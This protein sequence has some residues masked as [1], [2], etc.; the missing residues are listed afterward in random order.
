MHA[1]Y[2]SR[3]LYQKYIQREL[4]RVSTNIQE[5][6]FDETVDVDD[7]L[8]GAEQAMFEITQGSIKKEIQPI[9]MLLKQAIES[10]QEAGKRV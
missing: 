2:H 4:I 1:E 9:S 5:R 10:I 7:L 8:N 6:A 3:I